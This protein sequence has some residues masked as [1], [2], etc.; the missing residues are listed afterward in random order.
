MKSISIIFAFFQLTLAT[1]L[2]L[3]KESKI[4]GGRDASEHEAPYIVS[5]QYG[6]MSDGIFRHTCGGS[7]LNENWVLSAGHCITLIG[8]QFDYQIVAGQHDLN[9][10]SGSE[11]VRR[12]VEYI[13]HEDFI[14]RPLVGPFDI[15]ILRLDSPLRLQPGVV[16]AIQLPQSGTMQ[17]GDATLYGWGSTSDTLSPIIP[18][19]LQTVE[20]TVLEFE[21]CREIINTVMIHEFIHFTSLCTATLVDNRSS[22]IG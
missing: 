21:A 17:S 13:I 2:N 15:M 8:F 18:N 1:E 14:D 6:R 3:D 10:E 12:V 7:I 19:I 20:L 11:Q 16:E 22:C 4:V 5:L 9:V